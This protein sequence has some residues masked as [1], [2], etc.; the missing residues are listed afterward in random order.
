MSAL[1]FIIKSMFPSIDASIDENSN[2]VV[3]PFFLRGVTSLLETEP[4]VLEELDRHE[5]LR[6]ELTAADLD[7]DPSST[8]F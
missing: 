5:C 3:L 4:V 6:I 8:V 1:W 2:K 7:W